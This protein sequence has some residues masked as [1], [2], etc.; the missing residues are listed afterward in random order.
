MSDACIHACLSN[1]GGMYKAHRVA[2][3]ISRHLKYSKFPLSNGG[4]MKHVHTYVHSY[5]CRYRLGLVECN[6]LSIDS[7]PSC[8]QVVAVFKFLLHFCSKD[9]IL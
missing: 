5:M 6:H 9:Y 2:W 4:G 7:Q 3:G 1:G 8:V